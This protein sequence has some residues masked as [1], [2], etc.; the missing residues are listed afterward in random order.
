MVESSKTHS[1]DLEILLG[2]LE[3]PINSLVV[4][5]RF[6]PSKVGGKPVS[7]LYFKNSIFRLG[8]VMKDFHQINANTVDIKYHF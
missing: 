1:N 6:L 7:H 5:S 8:L 4:T 3:E 2:F